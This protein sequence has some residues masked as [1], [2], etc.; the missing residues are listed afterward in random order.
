MTFKPRY[1]QTVY[2]RGNPVGT[3]AK[4]EKD[5]CCYER[6]SGGYDYF[7]WSFPDG[8]NRLHTWGDRQHAN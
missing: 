7:I 1:R 5:I 8:L 3:V 6:F 4:V 2:F